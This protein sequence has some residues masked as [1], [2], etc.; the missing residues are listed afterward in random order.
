MLSLVTPT[1]PRRIAT[2]DFFSICIFSRTRS[3]DHDVVEERPTQNSTDESRDE[4]PNDEMDEADREVA[5]LTGAIKSADDS[6]QQM[7]NACFA[8]RASGTT[9]Q[10]Y[11]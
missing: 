2:P 6:N 5:N 8:S 3:V 10:S 9:Q 4:D 11:R 1:L 7:A